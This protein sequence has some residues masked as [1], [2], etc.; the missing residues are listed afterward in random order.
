MKEFLKIIIAE[1][2]NIQKEVEIPKLSRS[3]ISKAKYLMHNKIDETINFHLFCKNNRIRYSKFRADFKHQ[4][5]F[6][7]LQ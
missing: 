5:G 7:P 1:I 2:C 6:A 3:L 4:T